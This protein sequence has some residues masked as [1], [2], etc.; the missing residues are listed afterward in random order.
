MDEQNNHFVSQF[1]HD[2]ELTNFGTAD[3]PLFDVREISNILGI[4]IARVRAQLNADGENLLTA[5]NV[6]RLAL[7]RGSLVKRQFMDFILD[8]V[9]PGHVADVPRD[10]PN[11]VYF[12]TSIEPNSPT[13]YVKISHSKNPQKHLEQ[14]RRDFS[15]KT[16][17]IVACICCD[18]VRVGVE[19]RRKYRARRLEGEWFHFTQDE[20]DQVVDD[21]WSY[22]VGANV[23]P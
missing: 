12:I 8:R 6:F 16:H 11:Y 15:Y 18:A 2:A 4:P 5:E 19:L 23:H 3:N 7:D 1:F 13:I 20:L 17:E 21:A 22:V 14:L 9:M 10:T